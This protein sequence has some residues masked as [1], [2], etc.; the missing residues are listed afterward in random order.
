MKRLDRHVARRAL[1]LVE[2]VVAR[3]PH[4]G[5]QLKGKYRGLWSYRFSDYRIVYEIL[6]REL[7]IVVLRVR[8]RLDVYDG[9]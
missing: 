5:K 4:A 7:V 9:L 8:H 1:E 6:G 2:S 3:D